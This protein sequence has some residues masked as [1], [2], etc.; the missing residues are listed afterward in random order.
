[1]NKLNWLHNLKKSNVSSLRKRLVGV[2]LLI[3]DFDGVL[4]NNKVYTA[5][6]GVESVMCDRGDGL[7]LEYLKKYTDV[8]VLILSR[9][10]NPVTLARAKKLGV[11]CISGIESK[12][13]ILQAEIKKRELSNQDV[14][15]IGNDLND[16]ECMSNVAVRIAVADAYPQVKKVANYISKHLGGHGA[17]REI[18]EEIMRAKGV[19][20]YH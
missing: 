14:A 20:P 11:E 4:T 16:I 12:W 2:K 5:Q 3:L 7:G 6:D 17:V 10:K 1:M 13:E 8:E 19:H 18:C 15:F 9:E